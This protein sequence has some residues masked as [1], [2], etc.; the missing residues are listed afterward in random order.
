MVHIIDSGNTH[1]PSIFGAPGFGGND[2][3]SH[4]EFSGGYRAGGAG[5]VEADAA[6]VGSGVEASPD[7]AAFAGPGASGVDTVEDDDK[8]DWF[9]RNRC[10]W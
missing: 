10:S 5:S 6:G 4:L 2:G 1:V 9:C 3:G 8:G 7:D